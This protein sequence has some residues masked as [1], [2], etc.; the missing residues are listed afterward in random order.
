MP[1]L[2]TMKPEPSAS[3]FSRV[4]ARRRHAELLA[5]HPVPGI[6]DREAADELRALDGDDRALDAIDE[7]RDRARLGAACRRARRRRGR[8]A[9]PSDRQAAASDSAR[10]A[11]LAAINDDAAGR[12]IRREGDRHLVAENHANAVLAQLAAEVGEHLVAV[13]ELDAEISRRQA[14]R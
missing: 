4:G 5:Q 8:A 1:D 11:R 3:C 2:S 10:A 13:L 7:R 6:L 14:P 12:I 9:P